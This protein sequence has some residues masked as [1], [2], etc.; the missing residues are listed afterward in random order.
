MLHLPADRAL[1]QKSSFAAA[2]RHVQ[3]ER[4]FLADTQTVSLIA[5]T[6]HVAAINSFWMTAVLEARVIK[7]PSVGGFFE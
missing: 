7:R 2:L 3:Q 6:V 5:F 1:S 4:S